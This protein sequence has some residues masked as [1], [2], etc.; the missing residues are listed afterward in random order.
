[1]EIKLTKT[2]L[3]DWVE[4]TQGDEDRFVISHTDKNIWHVKVIPK[5]FLE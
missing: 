3:I 2:Q 4:K 1:M 5:P